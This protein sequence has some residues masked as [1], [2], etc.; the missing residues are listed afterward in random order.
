MFRG[1]KIIFVFAVTTAVFLNGCV[2]SPKLFTDA[3]D[4]LREFTLEGEGADRILVIPVKGIISDFAKKG[5]FQTEPSM[6]Q[7]IVSQL[8]LAER[9]ERVRAVVFKIDSPGGTVTASDILY[10]EIKDFKDR[11]GVKVTAVLMNVAA[12]GGY[13]MALP[14][15]HIMAHPTSITGSV[16]VIFLRPKVYS[17]MDKIG[18]DVTVSASGENK[19]MG[20]PFRKSTKSEDEMFQD[21]T[22]VLGSRF[23]NLVAEN[24]NLDADAVKDISSARIYIADEALERGLI[25]GIGYLNDALDQTKRIAGL[26][27]NARVV[28]Y[29][30]ERYANDNLYNTQT[31]MGGAGLSLVDLDVLD[32]PLLNRPGF[33]YLWP[34][35]FAE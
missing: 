3:A 16:G 27:E 1:R 17:L 33:Y 32:S 26:P 25:D 9:D 11:T 13:Y 28:V 30:R 8:R 31:R 2:M 35:G 15:D 10:H 7:E 22:N 18:V 4:P 23:I 34:A 29:R 21:M 24:R 12:S 19:D 20:S 14:A 5:V 6:V